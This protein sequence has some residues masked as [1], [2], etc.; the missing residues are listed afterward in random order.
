V[1]AEFDRAGAQVHAAVNDLQPVLKRLDPTLLKSAEATR[2]A[3]IKEFDR[4]R[5]RVLK[6]EKRRH[7]QVRD[8]LEKAQVNLFPFG[9]PQERVISVLY[10]L[11]KY[12][13][14]FLREL[15]RDL[16]LDTT[17]HQMVYL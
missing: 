15:Q 2:T 3:L 5:H 7:E 8:K 12:G 1:D 13:P 6:A 4:F 17:R 9:K 10:F 11:N 14:S 16:S